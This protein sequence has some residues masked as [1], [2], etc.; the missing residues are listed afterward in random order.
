LTD[1]HSA[2]TSSGTQADPFHAF[3]LLATLVAVVHVDG[4]VIFANSALEDVMGVSRRNIQG[5]N[6]SLYF[7]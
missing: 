7:T 5:T 3:D 2:A 4:A 6:L 1:K